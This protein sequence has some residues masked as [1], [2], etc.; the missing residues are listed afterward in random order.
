M[1][2][3]VNAEI[4]ASVLRL[5]GSAPRSFSSLI[6]LFESHHSPRID[7]RE[8]FRVVDQALQ[9]LVERGLIETSRVGGRPMWIRRPESKE[10]AHD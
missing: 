2:D 8:T 4:E 10:P 1:T 7:E 6:T 5:L 3:N 9:R